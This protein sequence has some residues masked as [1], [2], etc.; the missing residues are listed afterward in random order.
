VAISSTLFVFEIDLADS[1]RGVYETL[2]LRVARHPSESDDYLVARI[3]AYCLEYTDGI[4]F[5]RGLSD[6][7]EPPLAVR[8]LTGQM[9]TWIDVGTPSAD[10]LHRASKS[11]GRVVVYVHKSAEQWLAGLAAERIHNADAIEIKRIDRSLIAG[12][13]AAL[14]RRMSMSVAVAQNEVFISLDTVSFSGPIVPSF[15]GA[16]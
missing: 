2:S 4:E 11:V 9:K 14:D 12:L 8:D 1:D 13:V 10:R 3:L 7:D 15:V 16:V 5:S 6:A